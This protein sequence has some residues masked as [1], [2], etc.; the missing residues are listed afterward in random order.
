MIIFPILSLVFF[1]YCLSRLDPNRWQHHNRR[2][3]PFS[4]KFFYW[5][6]FLHSHIISI[7][8]S[9]EITNI[10]VYIPLIMNLERMNC[11]SW[12]ELF[13]THYNEFNV[14]SHLV[15]LDEKAQSASDKTERR[16]DWLYHQD[17]DLWDDSSTNYADDS[18][19]KTW[20]L[21]GYGR[22]LRLFFVTTNMKNP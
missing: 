3:I 2:N 11:N 17:E 18:I 4:I 9:Y 1:R 7:E 21:N 8:E 10:K 6:S 19:E 5:F 14:S 16:S 20:L 13:E 15:K 22:I 12:C